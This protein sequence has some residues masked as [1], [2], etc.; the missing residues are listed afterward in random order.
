MYPVYGFGAILEGSSYSIA[1]MCFNINFQNNPEIH[2]I[3]NVINVYHK[4]LD[5]LTFAGP[6]CFSPIIKRVINNIR[7]KKMY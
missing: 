3:D 1:S 7:Q 4:C 6:T 2:T 5:K